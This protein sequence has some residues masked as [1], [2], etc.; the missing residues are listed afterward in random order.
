MDEDGKTIKEVMSS[1]GY[2]EN[3]VTLSIGRLISAGSIK[4]IQKDDKELFC[5]I[6]PPAPLMRKP[7][8]RLPAEDAI[9]AEERTLMAIHEKGS[10]REQIIRAT[11]LP[12]QQV[13]EALTSLSKKGEIR[14]V[15]KAGKPVFYK[16]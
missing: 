16:S 12:E 8:K 11:R 6:P 14:I 13:T 4:R 10:T 2:S 7:L 5:L 3:I 15:R 1:T 9:E